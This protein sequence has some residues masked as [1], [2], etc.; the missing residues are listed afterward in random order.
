[1]TKRSNPCIAPWETNRSPDVPANIPPANATTATAYRGR[2]APTPS[3]LLHAGHAATFCH[4][5]GRAH[6]AG[7]VL[8]LRI[9]D[10]DAQRCTPRFTTAAIEDLRWLG[11]H[12]Q[13][14][15][16]IGGAH[17]PYVQSQRR[18]SYLTTW[19]QLRD[20]GFIYPC[21]RSRKDVATAASAPHEGDETEP[22]FPP[23][24]RSEQGTGREAVTPAGTNWRFRVPD[25]ECISFEDSLKGLQTFIAGKDFGDFLVW[26]RDDAPAYELAVVADDHAMRIT[27][28]V[29]GEDLLKS[30]A[31]QILLYRA[32]GW[33]PPAW[34][35]TPL[36]RD[37]TGQR[38]AKRNGALS[39]HTLRKRGLTPDDVRALVKTSP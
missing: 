38:L 24:W 2:L 3:G 21:Q 1:M 6:Q 5:A 36:V 39:L 13:E 11:L 4:A 26:R 10:L 30:T 27:E 29:R 34:R 19:A 25:G 23:Q 8:V 18:E 14:G 32:L 16:D 7:G 33:T 17:A 28:V 37:A 20:G 15:P 12:W 9:E 22:V 35:H 31:R